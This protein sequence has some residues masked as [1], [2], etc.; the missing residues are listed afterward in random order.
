MEARF[1][2]QFCFLDVA[3]SRDFLSLPGLGH[4]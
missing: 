2:T 1:E 4:L 3:S